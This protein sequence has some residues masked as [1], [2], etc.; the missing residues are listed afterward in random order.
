MFVDTVGVVAAAEVDKQT[1]ESPPAVARHLPIRRQSS[2]H[3]PADHLS[4]RAATSND[5][6]TAAASHTGTV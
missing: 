2:V 6:C 5:Y 4:S 1:S 3:V